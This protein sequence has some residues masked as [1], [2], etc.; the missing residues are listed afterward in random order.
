MNYRRSNTLVQ[1]ML[2][3]LSLKCICQEVKIERKMAGV[4]SLIIQNLQV[5][6]TNISLLNSL[7]Q[8][9]VLQEKLIIHKLL[10]A[11]INNILTFQI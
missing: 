5:I 9:Q 4:F 2:T 11:T 1:L 3:S 7:N 6:L 8:I 10:E